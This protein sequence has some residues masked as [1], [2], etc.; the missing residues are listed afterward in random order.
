VFS[1]THGRGVI[2]VLT[3]ASVLWRS[4]DLGGAASFSQRPFSE[5][6]APWIVALPRSWKTRPRMADRISWNA[7]P[8]CGDVI[9]LGW[10]G[11]DLTEYDCIRGCDLTAD[12]LDVLRSRRHR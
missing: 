12:E 8:R 7:C 5:P 2:R 11:E 6:V 4:I 10:D 1:L 9:A 3:M